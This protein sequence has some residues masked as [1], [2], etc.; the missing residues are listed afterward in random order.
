MVAT[1]QNVVIIGGGIVGCSAALY[2]A[3][4][5]H[6][7]RLLEK[8]RIGW[9]A[10]GRNGGAIRRHGRHQTELPLA[11]RSMDL[12]D[13]LALQ[14]SVDFGYRRGGDLV[15]AFSDAEVDRLEKTTPYYNAHDVPVEM[16]S[17][18]ALRRIAPGIAGSV[19]AAAYC[20]DDGWA[21][22]MLAVRV[23]A[24]MARDAGAE[25]L[26]GYQVSRAEPGSV[27]ALNEQSEHIH[28]DCDAIVHATGPWASKLFHET[29]AVLPVFPRRSQIMVTERVERW[30]EPFVSGNG[31]YLAQSVY[32]NMIIGGGGPWEESSHKTTGTVPTIHR[33][34]SKFSQVFPERGALQVIRAWAGTV[35]LTPDHRPF[36]GAVDGMPGVFIASGFCGNGFALGPVSGW[37][38][39]KL[40]SGQDP[41]VDL[42]PFATNRFESGV[43]YHGAYEQ[44]VR[45]RVEPISMEGAL[46]R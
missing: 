5:G 28:F 32:G 25:L 12:W 35:E 9:A 10:S 38:L 44:R 26:E 17:G 19:K 27:H 6:Q 1:R 29:S 7:V 20:P 31:I 36:I 39:S 22:P 14:S 34:S 4:A 33:L 42:Q 2:L 37:V 46:G 40:I 30:L 23:I 45:G 24:A 3:R 18:E 21:Y 43:D 8:A 13:D 41:G 15:V 16:L 11:V